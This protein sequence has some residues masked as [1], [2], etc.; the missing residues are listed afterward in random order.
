MHTP[1]I[2]GVRGR[3]SVAIYQPTPSWQDTR[4]KVQN[5]EK[6]VLAQGL[7]MSHVFSYTAVNAER[8]HLK[9]LLLFLALLVPFFDDS[10]ECSNT[11][12]QV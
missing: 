8:R 6:Q 1:G 2:D 11:S 9:N 10:L 12:L 7:E 5:P 4:N 3:H